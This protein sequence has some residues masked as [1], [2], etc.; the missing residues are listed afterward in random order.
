MNETFDVTDLNLSEEELFS[1]VDN[2]S[3]AAEN[4]CRRDT[5]PPRPRE[6]LLTGNVAILAV[7]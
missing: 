6:A 1:H 4:S 3:L 7:L 5:P 2:D